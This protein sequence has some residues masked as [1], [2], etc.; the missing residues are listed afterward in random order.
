MHDL[1]PVQARLHLLLQKGFT[2]LFRANTIQPDL[3][4]PIVLEHLGLLGH[5]HCHAVELLLRLVGRNLLGLD[6]EVLRS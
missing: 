1:V 4:A 2:K 5:L 6:A 3:L